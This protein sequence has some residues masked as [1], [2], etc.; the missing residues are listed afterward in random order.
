HAITVD[1]HVI[2][3]LPCENDELTMETAYSL[4]ILT[5]QLTK[6]YLHHLFMNTPIVNITEQ[7]E[8]NFHTQDIYINLVVDILEILPPEMIIHRLTGDGPRDLLI[9]PMWSLKK[10]DVL[11]GID[12]EL[13]QRNTW[14]GRRWQPRIESTKL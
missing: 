13:R 14:Q 1:A 9:G 6:I 5:V 8:L 7:G 12:R 11:N 4:S 10:W 2:L 3:G